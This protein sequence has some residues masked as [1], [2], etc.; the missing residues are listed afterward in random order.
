MLLPP[1]V[2]EL[3]RRLRSRA[4]DSEETIRRRLAEAHDQ[5][6][7]APSYDYVVV[8]EDLSTARAQLE[9]VLLAELARTVRQQGRLADLIRDLRRGR[10]A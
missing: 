3:E 5:I 6:R 9:A 8:N 2:D 4:T 7:G 10:S 1:S